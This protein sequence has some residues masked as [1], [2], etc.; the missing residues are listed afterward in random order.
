MSRRLRVVALFCFG[1]LVSAWSYTSYSAKVEKLYEKLP[2]QETYI[3]QPGVSPSE[4]LDRWYRDKAAVDVKADRKWAILL[5]GFPLAVTLASLAAK[6]LGWLEHIDYPQ[7][8]PGLVP[9]YFA[10]PLIFY[11]SGVSWFLLL[12]P[13]L[14]IAAALLALSLLIA[15]SKGSIN[16][17]RSFFGFMGFLISGAI[18]VVLW[19]L[20][21]SGPAQNSVDMAWST[22]FFSLEVSWAG[23]FGMGLTGPGS[24]RPV[25]QSP[26][27][28]GRIG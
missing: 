21:G 10:P 6:M 15:T 14:G 22:F 17:F 13:S 28:G 5:W 19:F 4:G 7:L 16:P 18:C 24:A 26:A 9:V 25:P 20:V 8:L 23:I 11:L 27:S 1:G 2:R 3:Y 12:V